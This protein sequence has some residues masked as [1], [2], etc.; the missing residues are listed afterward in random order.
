MCFF[1]FLDGAVFVRCFSR[2]YLFGVVHLFIHDMP[3]DTSQFEGV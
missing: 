3:N 2:F 1:H